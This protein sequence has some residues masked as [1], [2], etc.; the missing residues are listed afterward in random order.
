MPLF[1]TSITLRILVGK[2]LLKQ[3]LRFT[4]ANFLRKREILKPLSLYSRNHFFQT[5]LLFGDWKSVFEFACFKRKET[6]FLRTRLEVETSLKSVGWRS[7]G[8]SFWTSRCFCKQGW[9]KVWPQW[10]SMGQTKGCRQIWHMRSSSTS[11]A[12]S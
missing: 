2:P 9:Q 6:H 11:C 7:M 12:Y 4:L 8:Q 10:R 5:Q 1:D 3:C